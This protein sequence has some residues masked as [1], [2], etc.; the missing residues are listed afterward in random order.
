MKQSLIQL[1]TWNGRSFLGLLIL[2]GLSTN[3]ASLGP[4][5]PQPQAAN[6]AQAVDITGAVLTNRSHDCTDYVAAYR[7]DAADINNRS[8]HAGS[9]T[10]TVDGNHCVFSSNGVPNHDFN[11]RGR[12][13]V[14][15]FAEQTQ[16]FRVPINPQR[17]S[18]PTALSLQY[19]NAIFLNGVKVDLLAAGCH[20]VADGKIGCNDVNTPALCPPLVVGEVFWQRDIGCLL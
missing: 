12:G 10:I 18:Q 16:V 4:T 19:D 14:N 20:G 3:G 15:R 8:R 11:D 5:G 17:S 7:A 6:A 13:F 2:A 1:L 9:L